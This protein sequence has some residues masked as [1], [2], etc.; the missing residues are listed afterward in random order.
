MGLQFSNPE[1]LTP[2]EAIRRQFEE[3]FKTTPLL[4]RWPLGT[5]TVN[6]QFSHYMDPDTDNA[7]IGFVLGFRRKERLDQQ[8]R[9]VLSLLT[10]KQKL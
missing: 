6:D 1:G 5:M 8:R 9:K 4:Q 7:W 3:Q 10:I 2:T